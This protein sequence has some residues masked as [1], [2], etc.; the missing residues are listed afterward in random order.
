MLRGIDLLQLKSKIVAPGG[1]AVER[2]TTGQ[3]K[4]KGRPV[5]IC[6]TD[7]TR[8]AV[9]AW[10]Q[11]GG[12]TVWNYLFPGEMKGH[13]S[14]RQYCNLVKQWVALAGLNPEHYG[15]HSLR[16]TKAHQI[17]I[18]SGGNLRAVQLLLGHSSIQNTQEYLG[19]EEEAALD[20]AAG[21]TI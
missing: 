9:E 15:T 7:R 16:R 19:V 1:Q 18:A 20:I 21:V 3:Q 8:K 4:V 14:T 11:Q 2:I 12:I 13:L 6:L 10:Y 5:Q 17:Y